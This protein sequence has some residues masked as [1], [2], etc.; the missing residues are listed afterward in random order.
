MTPHPERIV[1][2]SIDLRR[3]DVPDA[4]FILQ[5]RLDPALNAHL[6]AT[7]PDLQA[8]AAWIAKSRSDPAQFYFIVQDKQGAPQG[9][10]RV[11]DLRSDSFC[12]GS[13]II[14]SGA[15]RKAAI[16][17][18]LLIYEFGFYTLGFAHCHFDVRKDNAR[19]VDF[20]KRFGARIVDETAQDYLFKF[21]RA[22]YE[23]TREQYRAFLP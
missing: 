20:H 19:V 1:G 23:A 8:Q 7:P 11:Y 5:L 6:S 18:A 10:I 17:S 15:P 3:V 21:D 9:T 13:W 12:W 2:K 14:R 22:D 4:A 16:E